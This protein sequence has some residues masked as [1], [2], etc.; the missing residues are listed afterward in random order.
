MSCVSPAAP[1]RAA[2]DGPGWAPAGVLCPAD[3]AIDQHGFDQDMA[4]LRNAAD[5]PVPSLH[6]G[7]AGDR[8]KTEVLVAHSPVEAI[9]ADV[10]RADSQCHLAVAKFGGR[11]FTCPEE[12]LA[13]PLIAV[14][15]H[16]LEM[17]EQGN[18]RQVPS[19]LSFLSL[20]EPEVDDAHRSFCN[21]G[22]QQF[23]ETVFL[24]IQS[25]CQEVALLE[26]MAE[27]VEFGMSSEPNFHL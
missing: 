17:G 12:H 20:F 3:S 26:D 14:R 16:H 15:A 24:T 13:D 22:D 4:R 6:L 27:R 18:A 7:V 19:D 23:A 10:V 2:A 8:P 9:S 11:S 5:P 25:V 1:E 21:P